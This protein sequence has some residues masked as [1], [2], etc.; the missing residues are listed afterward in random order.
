MSRM[1]EEIEKLRQG[2]ETVRAGGGKK[3]IEEQ[4]ASGKLAARERIDQLMD[5]GT[6]KSS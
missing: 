4:H 6:L 2:E 1:R 3:K 5:P